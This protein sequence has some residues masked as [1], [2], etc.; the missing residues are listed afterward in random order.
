MTQAISFDRSMDFDY[1]VASEPA[2]G[3]RRL[4]ARNPGPLTFKGTNTY[5]VGRRDVAVIDPGPNDPIHRRAIIA[6]A[7]RGR[8]THILLTHTHRDH[9]AGIAALQAETG[10]ITCGFAGGDERRAAAV[11]HA[12]ARAFLETGFTPNIRLDD[13]ETLKGS[14]WALKAIHTPGHAPDH[15][16]FDLEGS[17]VLFSGDHV[18]GWN[19]SVIAPP[20]GRMSDYLASL[21]KLIEPGGKAHEFYL[22]GHGEIVRDPARLVRSFL[23]HRRMREAAIRDCV[24]E[25]LEKV[26]VI[27]DR[28]YKGISPAVLSAARLSVLAH[29]EHLVEKGLVSCDGEPSLHRRFLPLA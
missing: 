5:L 8:I 15:L 4:V 11:K 13:G 17:G 19:T 20:E 10:A 23:V 25:G 29:L 28:I 6:A 26:N 12:E 2:A 9:S 22:A 1:G 27:T 3:V 14:D 18:M 7:G 21:E 24:Q 16:C